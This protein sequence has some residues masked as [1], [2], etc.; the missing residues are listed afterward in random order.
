MHRWLL[1][2]LIGIAPAAAVAQVKIEDPWVRGTVFFQR[3]TG[4]FMKITSNEPVALVDVKSTAAGVAEVHEMKMDNGVMRMRAVPRIDI[5]PG[6][7]LK[8]E[9]GGYHVM[10]MELK[11]GISKGDSVPIT[12][13][14]ERPDK[15]RFDVNVQAA[16]RGLR[17]DPK[18]THKH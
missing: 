1:A 5:P 11:S 3:S 9:P 15:S 4:A 6:Q 7:S 16:G 18:D 8:L 14:F 10:L 2:L 17:D 13:V 12:L